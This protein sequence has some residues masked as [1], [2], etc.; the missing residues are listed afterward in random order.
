MTGATCRKPCGVLLAPTLAIDG[1][2][3]VLRN[4]VSVRD[5]NDRIRGAQRL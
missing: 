1:N 2:L 3:E 5:A 4:W